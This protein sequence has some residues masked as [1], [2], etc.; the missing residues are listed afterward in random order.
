MNPVASSRRSVRAV[1]MAGLLVAACGPMPALPGMPGSSSTAQQSSAPALTIPAA[2]VRREPIQQV[3]TYSGDVH[4]KEQ[5][6][7]LPKA[8]GRVARVLVDVGTQVHAGD[9]IAQLEQDTP[10]IQ[11]LQAQANLAAAAAKLATVQAGGRSDD[12]AAAEE[13]VAQQQA[14][15]GSMRAQGRSEDVA[16]AQA[17]LAAQQAKLQLM[18]QGGRDEAIAQAQAGLDAAQQ[19]LAL[20]EKGATD[21]VRQA[22]ASAVDADRAAVVAAEASYAALGGTSAADLQ[23]AQSQ[24]DIV[25]AQINAAQ[26]VVGSADAAL[27]NLKGSSVADVQQAQ[28]A[29]DQAQAQ[30][31]AAQT[32]LNQANNPTH[33]SIVQA[34]A[35]LAAAQVAHAAAESNQTALEQGVSGYC[36][37]FPA[38]YTTE[39]RPGPNGSTSG[40]MAAIPAPANSSACQDA[41]NAAD[42]AVDAGAKS[43]ESAQAQLD[44]LQGGGAPATQAALQAQ[45]VG[46][47]ALVKATKA[48]L[49]ALK[50]GGVEAQ[51]A[52]IQAQ[53]DQAQSGLVA[54]QN[55]LSV[56]EARL[57]AAKNGTLDA[58]RK[59]TQ[60][61]VD[62]ARERLKTD[63]ARLAQIVAG[64][65][66]EE[67]Q[68]AQDAVTQAEQQVALAQQPATAQDIQGQRALVEQARQQLQKAQQPYTTYDVQ[69]Q[70]HV[71][72][73]AEAQLR[74]RQQPYTDQDVQAADAGVQQA[75]AAVNLA[76]LGIKE[77]DITAPVDGIVFD[78]QVSPGALVGPTS[79]IVTLVPPALEIAVNVDESQI[80]HV[81]RGENVQLQVAAYPDQTFAGTV[82]AIAPAVDQKSRGV[83]V[84]IEPKDDGGKLLSGMLAEVRIVTAEKPSALVIP[85]TAIA[86]TPASGAVANVVAIDDGGKVKRTAVQIGVVNADVAEIVSGLTE[87]QLVATS[88]VAGL[89]DGDVVVPQ[90]ETRTARAR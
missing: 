21:D 6:T 85:R 66:D 46:G 47:Q 37:P 34:Q 82:T 74:A 8:S 1:A 30:L 36:A 12:V 27:A 41:K 22:A 90:V 4:A 48:R 32:A 39:T 89:N 62:A 40:V 71:V 13:A 19:K 26:S 88:N 67:V 29:Y 42:I 43:V 76:Q 50:T 24:V 77:T 54:A 44:L 53:R 55:T 84:R 79:P 31:N 35:A 56:A 2:Q 17:A 60:A 80:G 61:Q 87:G 65:Q 83:S 75:Q 28:S 68:A 33:A 9:V 69:Q 10:E 38:G 58:Q 11:M 25:R 64:P 78:R 20:L 18:V 23:T 5:L 3:V 14:R 49:D 81:A 51:R 59:A 7:V 73:Q 70:E 57:A 15:L 63:E 16:A 45:V 72:A 52:S 86:G